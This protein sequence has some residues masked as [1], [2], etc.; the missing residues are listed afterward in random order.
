M[1]KQI[2]SGYRIN[3]QAYELGIPAIPQT[4][5][6]ASGDIVQS[7]REGPINFALDELNRLLNLRTT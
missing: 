5:K 4:I 2:Y 3:V 7:L 6:G 1:T